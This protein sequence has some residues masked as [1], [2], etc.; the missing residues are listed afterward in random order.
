MPEL[1]M[2]FAR[3]IN[4]IPEFYMI[5]AEKI[6]KMPEFF[7]IFARKIYFSRIWGAGQVP[8]PPVSYAYVFNY[9]KSA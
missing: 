2:I 7:L 5:Y 4:K 3:E 1:Y 8:L 9:C 6:N